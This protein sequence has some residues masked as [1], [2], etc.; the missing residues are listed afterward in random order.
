MT[1]GM[2]VGAIALGLLANHATAQE[3]GGDAR[4]PVAHHKT[5]STANDLN[6]HMHHRT[7]AHRLSTN[8]AAYPAP[9]FYAGPRGVPVY[10]GPGYTY[11]PRQGIANQACNLPTSRCPNEYRDIQ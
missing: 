7:S 10:H 11:V 9:P 4:K 8:V 2:L 3:L 5:R 1:R 6:R